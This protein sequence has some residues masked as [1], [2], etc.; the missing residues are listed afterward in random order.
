MI[1]D[2]KAIAKFQP[3]VPTLPKPLVFDTC[4]CVWGGGV[5]SY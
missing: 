4:V 2:T 5:D 3:A 1:S